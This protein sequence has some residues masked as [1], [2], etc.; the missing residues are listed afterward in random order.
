MKAKDGA[1]EKSMT[2]AKVFGTAKKVLFGMIITVNVALVG[3]SVW[4]LASSTGRTSEP[5]M[6][7]EKAA[8]GEV[9]GEK[10]RKEKNAAYISLNTRPAGAKVFINGYFKART[11]ADIKIASVT[12][13]PRQ[14][15][16]NLV[17]P[18]YQ[19]WAKN[20]VLTRGK[21]KEFSVKLAKK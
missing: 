13:V 9:Y 19:S 1:E 10:I 4:I 3:V 21:T 15:S 6:P 16:I 20:V 11:P 8:P 14:Y 18:G 5:L 17:L 12:E 2:K 7:G